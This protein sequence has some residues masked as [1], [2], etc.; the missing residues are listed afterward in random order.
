[1]ALANPSRSHW[2]ICPRCGDEFGV[3]GRDVEPG[4]EC[5]TCEY[6]IDW[7]E[8]REGRWWEADTLEESRGER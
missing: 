4:E 3:Y 6:G 8:G 7:S 2:G 5:A 1:M